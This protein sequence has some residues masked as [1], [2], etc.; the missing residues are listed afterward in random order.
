MAL[1]DISPDA[2]SWNTENFLMK[3]TTH[4]TSLQALGST[5]HQALPFSQ[6]LAPPAVLASCIPYP[7]AHRQKWGQEKIL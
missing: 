2:Q 6:N 5:T 7:Q 1:A 4:D 3:H